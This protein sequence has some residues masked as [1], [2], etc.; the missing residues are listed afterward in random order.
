MSGNGG[1]K[2]RHKRLLQKRRRASRLGAQN[3]AKIRAIVEAKGQAW[4]PLHN[5]AQ[6][7]ALNH[8]GRRAVVPVAPRREK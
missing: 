3:V 6:V 2:H 7:Q 4:D 1:H 8:H 5:P